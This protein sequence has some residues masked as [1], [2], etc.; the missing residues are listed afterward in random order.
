MDL[1][2]DAWSLIAKW[3]PLHAQ[4]RLRLLCRTAAGI[5]L[6]L[7]VTR[8]G[9]LGA[10]R[11]RHPDAFV[12]ALASSLSHPPNRS[13]GELDLQNNRLGSR[14]AVALGAALALG[15]CPLTSLDLRENKIGDDGAA[16]IGEAL[17]CNVCLR[18]LRLAHNSV[19]D[20]GALAIASGLS[21][22][23]GASLLQGLDLS[24]G[25]IGDAG[26]SALARALSTRNCLRELYLSFNRIGSA[27]VSEIAAMLQALA[28]TT[29]SRPTLLELRLQGNVNVCSA[30]WLDIRRAKWPELRV[31]GK[32]GALLSGAASEPR[33]PPLPADRPSS[34]STTGATGLNRTLPSS[35]L[36]RAGSPSGTGLKS[37]SLLPPGW[38][39]ASYTNASGRRIGR[40]RSPTGMW[41]ASRASAWHA[42]GEQTAGLRVQMKLKSAAT[43]ARTQGCGTADGSQYHRA[44]GVKAQVGTPSRA[45]KH[46]R[47]ALKGASPPSNNGASAVVTASHRRDARQCLLREDVWC[48]SCGA[49]WPRGSITYNSL[50]TFRSKCRLHQK[51]CV[52][53]RLQRNLLGVH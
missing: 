7:P 21:R 30:A 40:F 37:A 50:A 44:R 14:G 31:L 29:G 11:M 8:D 13:L 3:M 5:A 26:A 33:T 27:G 39:D 36:G 53:S 23:A 18:A 45:T 15:S 43:A 24:H 32:T 2:V 38:T 20:S 28:A 25:S 9:K 52:E 42:S 34:S 35:S 49:L 19:G 48:A 46:R 10:W 16:A 12:R 4:A 1:P 41:V 22:A 47:S 6:T 17:G 51:H